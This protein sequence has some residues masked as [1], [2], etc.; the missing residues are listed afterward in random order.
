LRLREYLL[1]LED[2]LLPIHIEGHGEDSETLGI[3]YHWCYK[4]H[5]LLLRPGNNR[6]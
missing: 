1:H 2:L 3:A 4:G 5:R 6:A